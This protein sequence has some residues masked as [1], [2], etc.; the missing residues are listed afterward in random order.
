M[1][2]L[3]DQ[4]H[5]EAAAR[6]LPPL[7]PLPPIVQRPIVGSGGVGV[8]PALFGNQ[9]FFSARCNASDLVGSC[10]FA[11]STNA[12]VSTADEQS[13]EPV[14]GIIV[15]KQNDGYCTVQRLGES[16]VL[17]QGLTPG[18]R[19]FL[20]PKGSIIA[21]PFDDVMPEFVQ[22]VGNALSETQIFI[23]PTGKV[24]RRIVKRDFVLQLGQSDPSPNGIYPRTDIYVQRDAPGGPQVFFSPTVEGE[25][26]V[27]LVGDGAPSADTMPDAQ[28]VYISA[29]GDLYYADGSGSVNGDISALIFGPG[30]PTADS[31]PTSN[32]FFVDA[33]DAEAFSRTNVTGAS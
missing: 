10:V 16:M 7:A 18:K 4:V 22:Q 6:S 30:A 29:E 14:V 9:A 23:Q 13:P 19:Y 5:P 12:F 26:S 20:G 31:I 25:D 11:D 21:P 1:V 2:I 27:I 3:R 15:S 8:G 33:P 28:A 32:V 17:Y 24:T